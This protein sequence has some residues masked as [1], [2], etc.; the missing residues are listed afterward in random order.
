[1]GSAA[2]RRRLAAEGQPSTHPSLAERIAN[3]MAD[4]SNRRL[5]EASVAS[6]PP[7]T[8]QQRAR[9]AVLLNDQPMETG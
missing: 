6:A 4:E 5:V 8:K 7:L 9:L 2:E 1:M 3:F